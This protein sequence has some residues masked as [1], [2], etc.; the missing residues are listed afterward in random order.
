MYI[1]TGVDI[2]S[3]DHN[4]PVEAVPAEIS[5]NAQVLLLML[6]L[7]RLLMLSSQSMVLIMMLLVTLYV[8]I[9]V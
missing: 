3:T 4:V 9:V 6:R 2:A 5:V 7:L 8:D 1:N